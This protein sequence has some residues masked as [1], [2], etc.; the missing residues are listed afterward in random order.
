MGESEQAFY[1]LLRKGDVENALKVL[2]RDELNKP[3]Y[4][5]AILKTLEET[6]R[7]DQAVDYARNIVIQRP[8]R[9]RVYITLARLMFKSGRL[10]EFPPLLAKGLSVVD[11]KDWSLVFLQISRLTSPFVLSDILN[12]ILDLKVPAEKEGALL[13]H[14]A[15]AALNAAEPDTARTYAD[16]AKDKGFSSPELSLVEANLHVVYRHFEAAY[17]ASRRGV[18]DFPENLDLKL[19]LIERCSQAGRFDEFSDLILSMWNSE[20][21]RSNA[22]TC[23]SRFFCPT[24]VLRRIMDQ[25]VGDTSDRTNVKTS[26]AFIKLYLQAYGQDAVSQFDTSLGEDLPG[27]AEQQLLAYCRAN[28]SS[29]PSRI[30]DWSAK[31][32]HIVRK[33]EA[34]ATVFCFPGHANK[35]SGLPVWQFDQVMERFPVNV[36][37]PVDRLSLGMCYGLP[38]IAEDYQGTLKAMARAAE[39]LGPLPV[40]SLG[41]SMGG[42]HAIRIAAETD[43]KLGISFAGPS[44][45][46]HAQENFGQERQLTREHMYMVPALNIEDM[47]TRWVL[48]QNPAFQ[49]HYIIGE[50]SKHDQAHF[51]RIADLPNCHPHILSD[52]A[53]HN[54]LIQMLLTGEFDSFMND[55]IRKAIESA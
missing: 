23:L 4:Q 48:E 42:F 7:I 17:Q 10:A 44:L 31:E 21:Q 5:S 12:Q 14:C 38:S 1:T 22:I 3:I 34:V 41:V 32:L 51:T 52:Y 35:F 13:S 55:M 30:S 45:I 2:P 39:E 33:P 27:T 40:M 16:R 54:V 36:I 26:L 53:Q 18:E 46:S 37:Y 28:S 43:V 25:I 6:D 24:H 15:L 11:V 19:A 50:A 49:L 47:D 9:H 8:S 29:Q 20:R